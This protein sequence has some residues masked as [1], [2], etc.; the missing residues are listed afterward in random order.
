M[1]ILKHGSLLDKL[2]AMLRGT[3]D[4]DKLIKNG[5]VIGKNFHAQEGVIIDPGHCWL[6]EIGD[7]VTLA[8]KC[9]ILAHDASTKFWTG[10]TK[11]GTVKI[12]NNVFVGAGSIILPGSHIEDNVIVGAGSLVHGKLSSGVYFGNPLRFYCS[13][14][15]YVKKQKNLINV[16]PVFDSNYVIGNIT[17]E[18]K[19]TMKNKLKNTKGYVI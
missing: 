14:E 9:H 18:R 12:G 8:P 5:L 16:E 4:I 1:N 10:Y 19:I 11:I 13:I 3:I 6:I 7:N 2:K 17:K 15:E